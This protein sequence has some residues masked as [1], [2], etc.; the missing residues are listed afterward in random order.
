MKVGTVLV[1]TD[2]NPLYC[3]FIPPFITAWKSIIPEAD[4]C[5]VLIAHAIPDYL[6]PYSSSIRLFPPIPGI[7]TA[8]QAQCI[9]L[10]YPRHLARNEGVLITDMDM[11]PMSRRYYTLPIA[12]L[13]N[14]A[15][16]VYRD[17]CLPG[18]IS[19]CYNIAHPATWVSMFGNGDLRTLMTE[20]HS[21]VI[22][23]GEHGGAGWGTD[24]VILANTFH[25]WTGNKVVLNDAVTGFRRLDRSEPR[26]FANRAFLEHYIRSGAYADY[27]CLRPYSQHRDMNDFIVSCLQ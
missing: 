15:F 5:I 12:P 13:P 14:D 4:I 19:M 11:L 10:L 24:Q 18:E 2:L 17:V 21:R 22:Y 6:M 23:S 7:H 3:E 16:V 25:A 1:A 9:R 26:A 8:F 20:W 27:H